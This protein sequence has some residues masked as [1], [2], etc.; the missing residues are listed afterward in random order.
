V[1][2]LVALGQD[3]LDEAVVRR[4]LGILVKDHDD[5]DAL[6]GERVATLVERAHQDQRVAQSKPL[7]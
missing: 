4:T 2:A 5:L 1:A 7:M 3:R 6:T